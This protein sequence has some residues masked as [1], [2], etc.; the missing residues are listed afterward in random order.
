MGRPGSRARAPGHP[1]VSLLLSSR[2]PAPEP[3]LKILAFQS[4]SWG[5]VFPRADRCTAGTRRKV[6]SLYLEGL[7]DF[8][9]PTQPLPPPPL[10]RAGQAVEVLLGTVSGQGLDYTWAGQLRPAVSKVYR[11]YQPFTFL[12]FSI[13]IR[14]LTSIMLLIKCFLMMDEGEGLAKSD[15][16]RLLDGRHHW[17]CSYPVMCATSISIIMAPRKEEAQLIWK[18]QVV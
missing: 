11:K 15:Q 18:N 3:D 5:N 14:P 6:V 8:I 13:G 9:P 12:H 16:D 4:C 7:K 2:I 10:P 17:I 1:L